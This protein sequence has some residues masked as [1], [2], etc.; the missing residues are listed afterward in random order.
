[1]FFL[2]KK[3]VKKR[4]KMNK[5]FS[6]PHLIQNNNFYFGKRSY[7][8]LPTYPSF[9]LISAFNKLAKGGSVTDMDK[10]NFSREIV[11]PWEDSLEEPSSPLEL[12]KEDQGQAVQDNATDISKPAKQVG[13]F[14]HYMKCYA[15]LWKTRLSSLVVMT[16]IGAFY[17]D[18]GWSKPWSHHLSLSV[19]TFLQAACAN[20][21]NEIIEVERDSIM[22]RTKKRP[23][24]TK[25][26]SKVH[27]TAQ[28]VFVGSLGTYLLYKHNNPTTAYLGLANIFIY[29]F[30]YT[31]LKV[32]HWINTWVGTLNG[33][34]PPLM[35]CAAASGDIYSP[36]ALYVFASMYLWQISHFMAIGY[37]C[38]G[39]YDKAGYK[40]LPIHQPKHAAIQSVVHAAL[41][42][43]LCWYMGPHGYNV[44]PLWF[45]IL[46]APINYYFLLKPSIVFMK[47]I[48]Y[49]NATRLFFK[50]LA[51]LILLF[52]TGIVAWTTKDSSLSHWLT[53]KWNAITS[54]FGNLFGKRG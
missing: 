16:A 19:G 43:P 6:Q 52:S 53:E 20:S 25:R 13:P 17:S 39:D 23:L 2:L 24:P 41:L 1:M 38:K 40:M 45:S 7:S 26:I 15:E 10:L 5:Q 4:K 54:F 36:T 49:D 29:A 47:D 35:G 27:A 33:S 14:R 44:A 28:A 30:V 51:H 42:L 31:P 21:L 50:S 22:S 9:N 3:E 48:N 34:L 37:K 32:R 18:G 8:I 12:A 11:C 46:S